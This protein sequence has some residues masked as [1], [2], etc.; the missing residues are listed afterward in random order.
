MIKAI[1][2]VACIVIEIVFYKASVYVHG[3]YIKWWAFI[4]AVLITVVST[5]A[6]F[7]T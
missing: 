1:G 5:G 4:V 2:I 6:I 3:D 7:F